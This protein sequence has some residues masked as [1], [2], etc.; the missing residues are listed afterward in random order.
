MTR[1]IV[2]VGLLVAA[3]AA[4]Y[5]ATRGADGSLQIVAAPRV[6]ELYTPWCPSCQR[7]RPL[8]DELAARCA[9][10]GVRV[11]AVDVSREENERIAERYGV[12]AVPTFLFLDGAGRE[13]R[14]LVGAQSADQLRLG[15]EALGDGV[16]GTPVSAF[17]ARSA[18]QKEG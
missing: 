11:E 18:A 2:V 3:A 8:V 5:L 17:G 6:L 10:S 7:M 12:R 14:R 15:L 1:K 13:A 9:G 4:G 16:C